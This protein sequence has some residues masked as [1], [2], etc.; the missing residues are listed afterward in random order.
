MERRRAL[1]VGAGNWGR[2]W[3]RNLQRSDRVQLAGWVDLRPGA[4]SEAAQDLGLQEVYTGTDLG[5]AMAATRPDFVVNVTVPAAHCGVAIQALEA[6]LPVLCEKPMADGMEAARAMV[7]CAERTGLLLMVSQQRRYNNQLAAMRRLIVDHLGP[8]GILNS[9][10]YRGHPQAP[11]L[12]GMVNPLLLD[13]AIHVF[14]AARYLSGADPVSVYCQAFNTPWSWYAGNASAVA[15]FEMTGKLLYTYRG[16]VTSQGREIPWEAEWRAVGA[17]G[18]A[19]W[20]GAGM[21]RAELAETPG[22]LPAK[23]VEI[24]AR[25]DNAPTDLAG[26][27]HDFL[28][29]L[30]TGT[31]PMGECH[32]N[33]KSLA[34]VFGAIE[35]AT[36]GQRVAITI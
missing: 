35:S 9:D 7:A 26:S 14:D 13:I 6:G 28:R 32:D 25:L 20:D 18:T 4:A 29:A 23:L 30:D 16:S 24:E 27:L 36:S 10:F 1:L 15:V 3:A 34:M 2:R 33:I 31:V 11:F 21:P 5:E 17:N 22:V 8:L 19:I 12:S